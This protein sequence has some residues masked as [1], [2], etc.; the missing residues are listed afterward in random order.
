MAHGVEGRF[1]F[2]DHRVVELAAAMPPQIKMKV[3][4]EKNILKKAMGDLVPASILKRPKQPYRAPEA[5]SFFDGSRARQDYVEEELSSRR[6]KECG[7]FNAASVELLVKKIKE[8]RAIGVKDNM[9]LVGILS[10]HLLMR[11]SWQ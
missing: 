1:P 9:A 3:L 6:I 10:T 7:I 5:R 2:L 4:N 11:Q 8:D